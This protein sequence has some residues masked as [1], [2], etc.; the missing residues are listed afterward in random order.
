MT[1]HDHTSSFFSVAMIPLSFL[2]CRTNIA[3]S[4]DGD[5][6]IKETFTE[7]SLPDARSS[8]SIGG[9]VIPE[10]VTI[11]KTQSRC[12][13]DDSMGSN[14]P[15]VIAAEN[16]SWEQEKYRDLKDIKARGKQLRTSILDD[17]I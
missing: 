17:F 3:S 1:A 2:V 14:E 9:L 7:K 5:L 4:V 15:S 13:K 10:T 8:D 6:L 16:G 12:K 11:I